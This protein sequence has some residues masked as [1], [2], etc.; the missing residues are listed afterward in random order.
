MNDIWQVR[1]KVVNFYSSIISGNRA[2]EH[3]I[4]FDSDCMKPNQK[5]SCTNAILNGNVKA[6]S[7]Y[8]V[9]WLPGKILIF[10][11]W[12]VLHARPPVLASEKTKR[13][14]KRIMIHV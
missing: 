1:G 5:D 2:K 4:R 6:E 3:L 14:L 11:N 10:D 13:I 9:T 7:I 12:R 8:S